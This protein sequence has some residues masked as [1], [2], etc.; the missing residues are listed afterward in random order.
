MKVRPLDANGDY[1]IGVP[2]YNNQ[3]IGVEQCIST[4]LKLWQGEWFLD[5]TQ[6]TPW[7]QSILGKSVNPDAF[8]KQAILGTTG[9]TS[10]VSYNSQFFGDTR[11]LNVSGVAA[12]L[13]GPVTFATPVQLGV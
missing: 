3:P 7:N 11:I 1:T 12:T 5:I 8:I 9:V 4:R 2:F 6:G 13:Y 10:I